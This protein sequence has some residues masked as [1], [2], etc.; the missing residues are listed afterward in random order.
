MVSLLLDW[1]PSGPSLVSKADD[2]GSTPLHFAASDGDRY[3][4]GAILRTVPPCAVRMRDSGGLSAL[5]IAAGMGHTH[6]AEALMKACPDAAKLRD[7][8]GQTFLHVAS[9][10][11][12][13]KVVS[14]A[15]N[16]PKVIPFAIRKPLFRGLLNAQ[17]EDGNTPLHLAVAAGAPAVVEALML[18]FFKIIHL[19]FINFQKYYTVFFFFKNNTASATWKPTGPCRP[20]GSRLVAFRPRGGRQASRPLAGNPVG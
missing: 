19:F 6:V 3:V 20:G 8:R 17:D 15:N 10:G 5:H 13:S 12:H 2:T 4:V 7:D 18:V 9:R 11:G 14:L 16:K 1:K